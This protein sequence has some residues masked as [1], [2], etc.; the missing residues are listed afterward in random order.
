MEVI[1]MLVLTR[2]TG[3][4]LIIGDEITVKVLSVDEETGQVRIGIDAPQAV[5]VHRREVFD[6][7]HGAPGVTITHKRPRRDMVVEPG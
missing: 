7:I 2:R 5:D 3:E 1:A 6:R 4:S